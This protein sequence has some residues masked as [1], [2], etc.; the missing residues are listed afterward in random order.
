MY[1]FKKVMIAFKQ[2]GAFDELVRVY[3]LKNNAPY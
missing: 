2:L 1:G 3:Q